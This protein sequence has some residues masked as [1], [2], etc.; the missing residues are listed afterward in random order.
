MRANPYPTMSPCVRSVVEAVC[1][2]YGLH[3][4][5]ICRRGK[6]AR[7]SRARSAAIYICRAELG[8]SIGEIAEEFALCDSSVVEAV[9]RTVNRISTA[10]AFTL[11]AVLAGEKAAEQ[12]NEA[13]MV[14]AE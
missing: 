1:E 3:P 12:W 4:T 13:G 10:D 5:K 14:A 9:E 7:I 2:V 6:R 8:M 11:K